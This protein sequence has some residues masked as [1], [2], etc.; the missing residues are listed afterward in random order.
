MWQTALLIVAGAIVVIAL[1]ALGYRMVRKTST[2]AG[3][4]KRE[5]DIVRQS[6]ERQKKADKVFA[7]PTAD[8]RAWLAK[9]RRRFGRL[10][11]A[12]KLGPK[13]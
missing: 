8:E 3:G 6:A 4:D 13:G 2:S 7:E 9:S 12:G 5:L 11:R 10:R 1:V